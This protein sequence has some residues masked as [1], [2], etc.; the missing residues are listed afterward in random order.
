MTEFAS[1]ENLK[2]SLTVGKD[3]LTLDEESTLAIDILQGSSDFK[4]QSKAINDKVLTDISGAIY[5][6]ADDKMCITSTT[7]TAATDDDTFNLHIQEPVKKIGKTT[8]IVFKKG[9]ST[10]LGYALFKYT[11]P[12]MG[13]APVVKMGGTRKRRARRKPSKTPKRHRRKKV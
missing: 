2:I 3:D 10:E 5:S 4:I 7:T 8:Y 1:I 13:G 11:T 6:I 9:G 12:T